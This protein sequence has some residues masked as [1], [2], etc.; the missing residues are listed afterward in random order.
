MLAVC[1]HPI[2]YYDYVRLVLRNDRLNVT[3]L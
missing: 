2:F 1:A 3:A